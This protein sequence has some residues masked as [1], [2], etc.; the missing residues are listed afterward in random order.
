M[1]FKMFCKGLRELNFCETK[2]SEIKVWAGPRKI[3]NDCEWADFYCIYFIY[4]WTLF[5]PLL[6]T[7]IKHNIL[8]KHVT[9]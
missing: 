7:H 9:N 3:W 2:I 1:T 8:L 5:F 6:Q 4:L